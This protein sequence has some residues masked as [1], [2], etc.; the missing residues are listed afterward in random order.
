MVRALRELPL[1]T[2]ALQPA[3]PKSVAN[4]ADTKFVKMVVVAE[5]HTV[6][7]VRMPR[8]ASARHSLRPSLS[9]PTAPSAQSVQTGSSVQAAQ[10]AVDVT[11]VATATTAALTA[12]PA[13]S[14]RLAQTDQLAKCETDAKTEVATGSQVRVQPLAVASLVTPPKIALAAA[15]AMTPA[16]PAA[17]SATIAQSADHA[18]SI[19][20]T[21]R[22][23]SVVTLAIV[24]AAS[25]ATSVVT[26][27]AQHAILVAIA[28]S[29]SAVTLVIVTADSTVTSASSATRSAQTE[30]NATAH[31]T[32]RSAMRVARTQTK[33]L[34]SRTRCWSDSSRLTHP[35]Q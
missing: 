32:T 26:T 34:F 16:Q 25:T 3:A 12:A 23:V 28:L 35:M 6:R 29:V 14:V 15:T 7:T 20:M 30:W 1:I 33:R 19:E 18:S 10:S 13:S 31:A 8:A 24:I 2:H 17:S 4:R 5:P 9:E 11:L 22:S 21:V 27:V